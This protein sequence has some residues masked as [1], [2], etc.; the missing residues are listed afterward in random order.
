MP[1]AFLSDDITWCMEENCP[2]VYCRRN[3]VHMVSR[4]GLH[5]YAFFK[6]T[7]E[8]PIGRSLDEC[9]NGCI[10]AKECFVKYDDPE[11]ALDVLINEYCEN[12]A[13]ASLEED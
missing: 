8:C 10:H 7:S 11:D 5:S 4:V 1:I 2:M 12:C 13:F 6:G 3:P 9:M